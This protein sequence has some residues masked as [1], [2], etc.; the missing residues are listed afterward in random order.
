MKKL[1]RVIAVALSV[2]VLVPV[3]GACHKKNEIAYTIGGHKFTSAMYSCVL[4]LAA[5]GARSDIDTFVKSQ[6]SDSSSSS[7]SSSS[8]KETDY[9][10]YK[11]DAEG[12]VSSEGTVSYNDYVKQQAVSTLK[13][14]AAVLSL[15]ESEG[16][17]LSEDEIKEAKAQASYYWNVGCDYSTY[18]YYSNYGM[19]PAQYFTPYANR[20][21]QNGVSESTY[22]Q[23]MIY[24]Y[25]Y[26]SYFDHLYNEGGAKEVSKETL[27]EYLTAHYAIANALSL[28][29]KDSKNNDLSEEDKAAVKANADAYA[30]RLESG[31]SFDTI[32]KEETKSDNSSGSSSGEETKGDEE[33]EYTPE[34]FVKLYGDSETSSNSDLFK[35]VSE[36][37]TGEIKVAEDTSNSAYV[38]LQKR[39]I[40][41]KDY[42]LKNLRSSILQTLKS[43]EFDD[44]LKEYAEKLEVVEDSHATRPFTVKKVKF[45]KA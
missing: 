10:K 23:Y 20:L 13:Q 4:T 44:M 24:Q 14:F 31:E 45:P 42:W 9:T 36:M 7:S 35:T 22:E 39:D 21:E 27:T 18:V 40:T 12:K 11:F 6:N 1:L 25:Q 3:L 37:K 30:A 8:S 2:A 28:T 32:Y 34:S 33:K 41:E 16:L 26:G 19:N 15:C 29:T 38:V 5:S 17:T 43:D